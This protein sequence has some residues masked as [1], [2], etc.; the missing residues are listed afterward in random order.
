M[1]FEK[2]KNFVFLGNPN[3]RVQTLYRRDR[4]RCADDVLNGAWMIEESS[5]ELSDQE[6]FWRP[7]FETPSSAD[8]RTENPIRN[9][10]DDALQPVTS[11]E[12]TLT[13]KKLKLKSAAGLDGR[14][15]KMLRNI[16]PKEIAARVNLW[17][18]AGSIP[19]HSEGA[20]HS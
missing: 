12:V 3:A 19:T 13:L 18:L 14:S 11:A 1:F 10:Q 6:Q 8:N 17:L 16:D 7:L 5:V 15:V 9:G 4:A 2:L 20:R